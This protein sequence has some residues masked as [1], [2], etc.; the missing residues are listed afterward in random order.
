MS[1]VVDIISRNLPQLLPV[2]IGLVVQVRLEPY[3]CASQLSF[4]T[5]A[6]SLAEDPALMVDDAGSRSGDPAGV[7]NRLLRANPQVAPTCLVQESRT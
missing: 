2:A 1:L 4:D 5:P 7:V 3:R 6:G